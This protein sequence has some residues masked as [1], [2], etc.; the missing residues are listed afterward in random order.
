M[1]LHGNAIN[2]TKI[3]GIS[4]PR[5]QSSHVAPPMNGRENMIYKSLE[6]GGV[7]VPGRFAEMGLEELEECGK[8]EGGRHASESHL[9]FSRRTAWEGVSKKYSSDAVSNFSVVIKIRRSTKGFC[10]WAQSCGQLLH[11]CLHK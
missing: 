1:Y 10:S 11:S 3:K 2:N 5:S 8:R 7:A 9:L 4:K 6:D